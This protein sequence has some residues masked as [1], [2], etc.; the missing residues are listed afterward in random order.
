MTVKDLIE[1]NQMI[2]DVE[3]EIRQEGHRL[4]DALMIGC[5]RGKKPFQP[6]MVP[7][8]ER[9]VGNITMRKEANYIDKSIN[10]WDDGK[11]YYQIKV[12][13]IPAKWLE[14]EVYSFEVWPA[15]TFGNP[16]RRTGEAKNVNF[17]GQRINIIALPSG[18]RLSIKPAKTENAQEK[19]ELDGQMGIE[20]FL[21]E[22]GE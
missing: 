11:D 4:V 5:E 6:V 21:Q 12:Q 15:S 13:R 20:E 9:Y 10:A 14:L 16:R 8:D 1:L 7:L 2:V 19:C 17:H 18:E 22:V 3:I